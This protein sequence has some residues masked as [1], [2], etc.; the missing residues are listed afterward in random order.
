MSEP[1]P[2][3]SPEPDRLSTA[4]STGVLERPETREEAAPGDA[5]RYAH[6]VKKEK[7][8]AAAVSG[9]P[10]VA[11]CGKVWT[12]TRDPSKFPVCPVC[13]EI[14]EG[15]TGGGGQGG[16][17]G[18]GDSGGGSGRSGFSGLFGFGSRR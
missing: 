8:T 9:G 7:I 18:D 16:N 13:K 17:S 12:P 15:M 11:L 14:Y 3:T 4:G 2:P 6:Y 1:L 5:E 10:V